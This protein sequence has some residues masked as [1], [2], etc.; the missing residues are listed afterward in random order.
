MYTI[1]FTKSNDW[2]YEKELRSI[3]KLNAADSIIC[4]KDIHILNVLHKESQIEIKKLK[5]R[6]IQITYPNEYEMREDMGD[7]SIKNE[8]YMST[9]YENKDNIHLFR[10]NPEAITGIYCGCRC[11]CE[12]VKEL[13][14][15]NNQ[16][17]HLN[18]A[19]YKMKIDDYKY[20]LDYIKFEL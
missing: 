12:K 5:N 16:L 8:I 4:R 10:I 1:F 17:A 9:N 11:D 15:G 13:V 7:E 14:S 19:I 2:I 18:N 20:E 3:V 6:K